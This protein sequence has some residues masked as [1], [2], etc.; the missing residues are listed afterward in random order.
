MAIVSISINEKML[1]EI[2]RLQREMGFS[3]RSEIVRAGLRTLIAENKEA[4][5]LKGRLKSIL[6]VVHS[7]GAERDVTE[8]KHHFEDVITTH[9]HSGLRND[10]CLEIFVLDGNAERIKKFLKI[11][12]ANRNVS[13]IRLITP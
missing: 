8:A 9:I 6:L 7:R 2:D 13:Y 3:G 5:E 12:R 11:N 1:G 4:G 10:K